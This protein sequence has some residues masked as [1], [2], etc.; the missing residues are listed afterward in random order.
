MTFYICNTKQQFSS[1][2]WSCLWHAGGR[3]P[4]S[5]L[6][7]SVITLQKL[8]GQLCDLPPC[9]LNVAWVSDAWAD[10][11]AQDKEAGELTRHQVDGSALRDPFEQELVQFV[12]ALREKKGTKLTSFR[13]TIA[14][15]F[16]C[17]L[18]FNKKHHVSVLSCWTLLPWA[19][20]TPGPWPRRHRSQTSCLL[21]Q[22][23]QTLWPG[24]LAAKRRHEILLVCRPETVRCSFKFMPLLCKFHSKWKGEGLWIQL[25]GV[26]VGYSITKRGKS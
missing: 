10:G 11:K 15:G 2:R 21:E 12:G 16:W 22:D 9:V 8:T 25:I 7:W 26:L 17:W 6:L 14:G 13:F 3:P 5:G 4:F 19:G 18:E 24:P 20:S 1:S 23:S